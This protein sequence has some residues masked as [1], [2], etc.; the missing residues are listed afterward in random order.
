MVRRVMRN[1]VPLEVLNTVTARCPSCGEETE[2]V[3]YG[4]GRAM[5]SQ[6]QT[7]ARWVVDHVEPTA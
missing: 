3:L 5:C 4:E 2:V 7:P 1:G 6:C